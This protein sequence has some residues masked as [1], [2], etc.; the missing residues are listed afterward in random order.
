MS[1]LQHG[2]R[3]TTESYFDGLLASTRQELE[4]SL[5]SSKESILKDVI[6]ALSVISAGETRHLTIEV[7]VDAKGQYRLVKKWILL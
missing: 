2:K 1:E 4:T 5:F 7:R 3:V 6:E